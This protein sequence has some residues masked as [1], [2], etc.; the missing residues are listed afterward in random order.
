MREK[1]Y[2]RLTGV[3]TVRIHQWL[4]DNH[5]KLLEDRC[6]YVEAAARCFAA[7]EINVHPGTL[8]H[9]IREFGLKWK[10]P[11]PRWRPAEQR[12]EKGCG[13]RVLAKAMAELMTGLGLPISEPVQRLAYGDRK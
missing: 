11:K 5:P 4:M 13:T 7:T 8:S 1:H 10:D 12:E 6:S 3:L 2:T 9:L